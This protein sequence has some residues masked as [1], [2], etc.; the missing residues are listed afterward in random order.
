MLSYCLKHVKGMTKG[1]QVVDAGFIWTEP[2]SK[3]LKVRATIQ[4]EVFSKVQM[5]KDIVVE[6]LIQ[7]E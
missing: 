2:H 7:N 3:R 6:F 5:K 1:T 4:R